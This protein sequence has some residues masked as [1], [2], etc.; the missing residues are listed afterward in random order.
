[1]RRGKVAKRILQEVQ[2]GQYDLLVI[3][4]GG[5]VELTVVNLSS[6]ITTYFNSGLGI[7]ESISSIL[8]G[9]GSLAGIIGVFTGGK[10]GDKF[11]NQ[12]ALL[13]ILSIIAFLLGLMFYVKVVFLAASVFII[14]RSLVSATMP[15]LNSVVALNSSI[16]HRS[17]AFWSPL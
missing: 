14:Y 13:I 4:A 10:M 2:E 6:F 12:K 7:S 11:G 15:L 16:E 8:F 3:T 5:F 17:L 9:L 1:V